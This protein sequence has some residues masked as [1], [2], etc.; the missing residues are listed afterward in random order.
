M[1]V[2]VATLLNIEAITMS[3]SIIH[4]NIFFCLTERERK[5]ENKKTKKQKNKK[6]KKQKI[7]NKTI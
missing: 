2:L 6:T 7:I 1:I 5:Q 3:I 4:S